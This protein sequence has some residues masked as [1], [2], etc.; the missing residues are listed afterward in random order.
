MI[1]Q[2]E[3]RVD[4]SPPQAVCA[5]VNAVGDHRGS[6]DHIRWREEKLVV[7]VGA[8]YFSWWPHDGTS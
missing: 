7:D 6:F 5:S 8:F 3:G 2:E 1:W 4:L